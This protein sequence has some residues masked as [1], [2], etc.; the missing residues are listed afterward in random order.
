MRWSGGSIGGDERTV[1]GAVPIEVMTEILVTAG[2]TREHLDDV[3]FLSNGSTGLMGYAIAAEA[4]G[5]GCR[6][7][8]VSGPTQLPCP[9]GVQRV[10]VVS[11]DEMLE[12]ARRAF[13]GCDIAFFVAA[14]ADHRPAHR[15][16][17]KPAKQDG[18]LVLDLVANPDIAATLGARKGRRICVGF[19]LEAMASDRTAALDR[20]RAKLRRKHFDL[21]VLNAPA[22]LAR[23]RSEITLIDA[24]GRVETLPEADKTATAAVIVERAL[25]L[26]AG[27]RPQTGVGSE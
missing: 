10:D 4:R 17:G 16:P 22:A 24:A 21:C 6:V 19:A 14:V 25:A 2:P 23:D 18:R 7:T 26:A 8:L 9:D 20:A 12:A 27:R 15:E 11:A 5:R 13:D 1:R 3:R